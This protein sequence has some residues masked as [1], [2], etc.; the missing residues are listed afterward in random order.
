MDKTN[1]VLI[2]AARN[3]EKYIENTIKAII[4]QTVLPVQWIIVSDGSTDRTDEIVM[5]YSARY[6]FIHLMRKT[7]TI[8]GQ[9]DFISD[10]QG[11]AAGIKFNWTSDGEKITISHKPNQHTKGDIKNAH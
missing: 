11:I 7:A 1:Y 3:E 5:Q 8:N 2:T 9:V 10:M 4:A 6:N